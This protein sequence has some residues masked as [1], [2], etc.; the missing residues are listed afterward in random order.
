[1]VLT[2][3]ICEDDSIWLLKLFH[4]LLCDL[5]QDLPLILRLQIPLIGYVD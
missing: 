1:M 2:S 5:C 4:S 3:A